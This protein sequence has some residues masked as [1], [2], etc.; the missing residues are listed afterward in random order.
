VAAALDEGIEGLEA[1]MEELWVVENGSGRRAT[2][3]PRELLRCHGRR[4]EKMPPPD[5]EPRVKDIREV[6]L[7]LAPLAP[8]PPQAEHGGGDD[9]RV[10]G[11]NTSSD[12][13]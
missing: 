9:E 1:T 11:A 13:N 5:A 10:H 6:A 12:V 2:S 7:P 4:L 8:P 3:G